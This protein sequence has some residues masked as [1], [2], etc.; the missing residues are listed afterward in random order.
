M[1]GFD[2]LDFLLNS[3]ID[4][5]NWFYSSFAIFT[6]TVQFLI[7]LPKARAVLNFVK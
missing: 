7:P 3:L 2:G 1:F 5:D 6:A 4:S